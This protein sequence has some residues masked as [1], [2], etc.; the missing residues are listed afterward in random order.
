MRPP[1]AAVLPYD[2]CDVAAMLDDLVRAGFIAHYAE[3]TTKAVPCNDQGSAKDSPPGN[4]A[5]DSQAT[6]GCVI[7]FAEHQRPHKNEQPSQLPA[8]Q[9][10]GHGTTKAVPWHNQGS[11]K[12]AQSLGC[13]VLGVGDTDSPGASAGAGEAPPEKP[14]KP[15]KRKAAKKPPSEHAEFVA[16][17][18]DEFERRKGAKYAVE[19]GKDGAAVNALLGMA[20]GD[21]DA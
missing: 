18:C 14:K 21:L 12:D 2:Q 11:A 8:P 3:S 15:R 7:R 17:W 5:A 20:G 6:Y 16:W 9:G 19:G 1:A 10:L 13:G 4:G